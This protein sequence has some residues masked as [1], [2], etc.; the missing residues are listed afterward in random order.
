M[1]TISNTKIWGYPLK[2]TKGH[3]FV[4]IAISDNRTAVSIKRGLLDIGVPDEKIFYK[5][6]ESL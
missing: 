6:P 4:V 3:N 1:Y 2:V 5:K